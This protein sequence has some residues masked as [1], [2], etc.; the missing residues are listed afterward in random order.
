VLT[1]LGTGALLVAEPLL[2]RCMGLESAALALIGSNGLGMLWRLA[3]LVGGR[4]PIRLDLRSVR[5]YLQMMGRILRLAM[6]QN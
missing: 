5:L 2:V 1:L 6:V 3:V 4:A